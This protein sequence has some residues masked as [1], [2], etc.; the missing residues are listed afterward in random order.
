[1]RAL[2]SASASVL[3]AIGLLAIL[4]PTAG[5]LPAGSSYEKVSPNDKDGQDMIGGGVKAAV[6]GDATTSTSFGAFGD[7]E[8]AG[9]LTSFH[10]ARSATAWDTDSLGPPQEVFAS[11]ASSLY[12]DFSDDVSTSIVEYQ[13]GDPE[14]EGATPGSNNIYRRDA[15]GSMHLL[16]PNQPALPPGEIFAP[17]PNWGG[18]PNDMSFGTWSINTTPAST[19]TSGPAAVDGVDNA[20]VSTG[21]NDLRL[22]SVL[23]DGTA[24]PNGGIIGGGTFNGT[25]Y[26]AV[27]DDGSRIFWDSA[28]SAPSEVYVRTDGTDTVQVSASQRT[29]PDPNGV[30]PKGYWYATPD[31]SAAFFT[32]GEKLT[33]NSQAEPGVPDLYR[34]NVDTDTLVDLTTADPDGAGIQGVLGASDS[35]GRV[36]FAASGALA[37]GAVDGETNLYV[38]DGTQTTFITGLD[39]FGDGDNWNAGGGFKTSRVSPS[40]GTVLFSSR[41]QQLGYDNAGHLEFYIYDL[42][43]DE[44]SCI[45]C[46]P[47]GDP[48]TADAAINSP[49]TGGLNLSLINTYQRR[50]LSADGSTAFFTSAERLVPSDTNGK[51]DAYM[52]NDGDRRAGLERPERRRLV[53]PGG[54]RQRQQ[55][56]LP[57]PPAAG[58]DRHRRFG[59]P[60]RRARRRRSG[61]PEPAPAPAAVPGRHLQAAGDPADGPAAQRHLVGQQPARA[62]DSRLQRPRQEGQQGRRQGRQAPKEGRQGPRQAEEEAQEEAQEGQEAGQVR[63]ASSRRVQ[64]GLR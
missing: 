15:D 34:Y 9:L 51:Y 64:P 35:G 5:A 44:L 24:S 8:G 42:A 13:G 33:N 39:Q 41:R 20:Y 63:P 27:S 4:A 31:G 22:V 50:N 12:Q 21:A 32:S 59:R 61:L 14:L 60:L 30:Q 19:V 40:G 36:Y 62:A 57:D 48:A 26:N 47:N 54:L 58:R 11:L 3:A 55:R 46:N 52:W 2:V 28:G 37:P 18:G 10:S 23:P 56:L 38:R 17:F 1:M 6:N 43:A 7:S 45:S 53:V 49:P 25:Q 16:S 29:N